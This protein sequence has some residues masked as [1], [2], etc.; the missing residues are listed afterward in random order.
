[1]YIFLPIL[2]KITS[3]KK[4]YIFFLTSGNKGLRHKTIILL[5]VLH[6]CPAW[7]LTLK[8]EHR[9]RVFENKVFRKRFGTKKD[10]ITG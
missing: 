6:R 3:K 4:C 2:N 8:E 7:S 10:E 9:L 5:V 1:M